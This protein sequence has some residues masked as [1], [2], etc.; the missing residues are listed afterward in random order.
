V[1]W[2]AEG[3]E[4]PSAE[5]MLAEALEANRQLSELADGLIEDNALLR[6]LWGSIIR[7]RLARLAG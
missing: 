6:E 5:C 2:D 4:A 1:V 3:A 7:S